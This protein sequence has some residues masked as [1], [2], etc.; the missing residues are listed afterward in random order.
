MYSLYRYSLYKSVKAGYKAEWSLTSCS[1]I[2]RSVRQGQ[3]SLSRE[4]KHWPYGAQFQSVYICE[5]ITT[6]KTGNIILTAKC[7]LL[8]CLSLL[9]LLL[10]SPPLTLIY[11]LPL[12]ISL[13]FT[14]SVVQSCPT[15]CDPMDCSRPGF[16]V[17]YH[18][19]ELVQ[20]HVHWVSD[21]IQLFHPLSSPPPPA[22]PFLAIR[23][24]GIVSS[25]S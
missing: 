2:C 16:P 18:L 9:S 20:T 11:F 22:F 17:L 21:A 6:L 4:Q 10:S 15:L 23:T 14:C 19:P 7:F 3:E 5:T 13:H 24:S 25:R 8:P 1:Q 12:C